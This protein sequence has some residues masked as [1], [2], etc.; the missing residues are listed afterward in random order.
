MTCG[1]GAYVRALVRD[2]AAALS[3]EGH[4]SALRRL[5]V[6]PFGIEQAITLAELEDLVHKGAALER[7]LPVET[8]LDDIPALA[9]TGEDVSRLRQGRAIVLLPHQAQELRARRRPRTIAGADASR[10]VLAT[11][12]GEAVALG[13]M[14]AGRFQPMRLFRL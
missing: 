5:R 4:V 11:H 12:A 8:A 6:G 1:K 10:L 9:V 7:L 14:R 13:E 3:A 2:L